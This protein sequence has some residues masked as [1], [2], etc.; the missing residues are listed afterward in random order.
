MIAQTVREVLDD[1]VVLD[2][3]GIDRLYLNLFQPRLQTGGGVAALFKGHREAKV[4]STTLMGPMTRDFVAAIHAFAEREGVELVH[5]AKYQR[6]DEV[7]QERLKDFE[8]SEGV[9]YI[10]VA[11]VAAGGIPQLALAPNHDA[12]AWG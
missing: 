5:F 2:I 11:A 6:K 4:V 12:G 7:T 1:Q 10:G 8:P 9:S 3:E